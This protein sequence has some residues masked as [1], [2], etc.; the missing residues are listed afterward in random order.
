MRWTSLL[1][2]VAFSSTLLA[3]V[4][5]PCMVYRHGLTN[6][7][8]DDLLDFDPENYVRALLA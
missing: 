2:A 3:K 8:M 4:I 1:F 6:E 5:L 7:Q